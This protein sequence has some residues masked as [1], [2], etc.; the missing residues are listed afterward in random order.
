[1]GYEF[2]F[3]C[4]NC[5]YGAFVSGGKGFGFVDVVQTMVCHDCHG[6]KVSVWEKSRPCPKCVAMMIKGELVELWN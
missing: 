3:G 2:S 5:V 6:K 4:N 1:M